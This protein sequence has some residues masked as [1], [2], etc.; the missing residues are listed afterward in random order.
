[1]NSG[2]EPSNITADFACSPC[3][4]SQRG[5]VE[6]PEGGR[7]KETGEFEESLACDPG[8]VRFVL[9]AAVS[10]ALAESVLA[11]EGDSASLCK[12]TP[13]CSCILVSSN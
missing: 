3:F 11:A 7:F 1:M 4:N 8:A 9:S 5:S 10:T 12:N 6:Q 2:I 13:I